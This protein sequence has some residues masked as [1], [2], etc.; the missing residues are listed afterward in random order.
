MSPPSLSELIDSRRVILCVGCG[1]VGKTT[2]A[3]AL[4]L[5]AA[6][7][8]KR[9]LT[10]TIDPAKRLANSLGFERMTTD[11]QD[12]E[13]ELLAAVG[14]PASGSL[15]VMMLDTK[16]TFDEL[17]SKFASSPEVRDRILGNRLYKYVST[18]LAGTQDYMAMEKLLAMKDDPRFDLVVLDTPPTRN[19]LDFLEAP[20]RLIEALDGP[21]IRW[22]IQAF[23]K[24]RKLSL[25]LVAQSV[26]VVLRGVGKLT[27]GGFLEQMAELIAD[28]N[29]LFGGF[30]DRAARVAAAF[31]APDFA[32]V[33]VTS[34]APLAIQEI[35][36][37][38]E[39]LD[40]RGMRS[41]AFVANRVHVAPRAEPSLEQIDLA[42]SRH[43]VALR[44]GAA[45]RIAHAVADEAALAASDDRNL[46]A[47]IEVR[48]RLGRASAP[49]I[50]V[51]ALPSD[52][53]DV[54]TLAGIAGVL[55]PG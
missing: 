32:Y 24:S 40:E 54:G 7:R 20:E 42:L 47:L 21:A 16:R 35:A 48:A 50:G 28:L 55:C 39:R 45:P 26:A 49:L 17:V 14:V 4:G 8:G 46:A 11:E 30:R 52:V 22:F 19:A 13:R 15:T 31:R 10:L 29:D 2:V 5:A 12:V 27:G 43:G 18:N 1:G 34:P 37:F 38:A 41:E 33:M 44:D 51:R 9:V 6:R 23:D 36:Y 3:A 25:N 53:H